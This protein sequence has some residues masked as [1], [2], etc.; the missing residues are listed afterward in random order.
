M[1][2][3]S[4]E[5]HRHAIECT[6]PDLW[7]TSAR[8]F[9]VHGC[10]SWRKSL[11]ARM[12]LLSSSSFLPARNL[13]RHRHALDSTT[14]RLGAVSNRLEHRPRS[15]S[16]MLILG[17]AQKPQY[18]PAF[19]PTPALSASVN[20]APSVLPNVQ[21]PTAPNAQ[22]ECPGYVASNV[23]ESSTGVTADLTL[24]GEPCN[25]YACSVPCVDLC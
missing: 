24:A 18:P 19:P 21:D 9:T 1:L 2:R 5:P 7:M 6:L 10:R 13:R 3:A 15:E 12:A 25:V 8:R 11:A 22:S 20:Y 16:H 4:Q 17:T 14:Q 23:Q